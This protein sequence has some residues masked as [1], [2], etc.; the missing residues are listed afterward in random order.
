MFPRT[1]NLYQRLDES[2]KFIA[3]CKVEDLNV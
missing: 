1:S 3:S 2:L